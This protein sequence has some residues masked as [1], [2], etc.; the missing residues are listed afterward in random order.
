MHGPPDNQIVRLLFNASINQATPSL[1]ADA[2]FL[3]VSKC[4]NASINTFPACRC[5]LPDGARSRRCAGAA[6][7]CGCPLQRVLP[8]CRPA[9]AACLPARLP[10]QCARLPA[11]PP[12]SAIRRRLRC[13]SC[14]RLLWPPSNAGARRGGGRPVQP[15]PARPSP[16]PPPPPR[17]TL[18]PRSDAGL[19]G[20]V[21]AGATHPRRPHHQRG[22]PVPGGGHVVAAR[23]CKHAFGASALWL[24]AQG[25]CG[26][27]RAHRNR[28]C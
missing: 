11:C 20:A 1:L 27:E 21:A 10:L 17:A 24:G 19:R 2:G 4:I 14:D 26:C 7:A 12:A 23:R 13:D 15:I 3:T 22:G 28:R 9:R 16:P 6:G 5:G 8:S 25:R 18:L